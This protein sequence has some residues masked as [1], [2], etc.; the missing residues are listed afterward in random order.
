VYSDPKGTGLINK[1]TSTDHRSL[2]QL[3]LAEFSDRDSGMCV[4]ILIWLVVTVTHEV[5]CM[6]VCHM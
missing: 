4:C 3:Q 6:H 1:M 5:L 2:V